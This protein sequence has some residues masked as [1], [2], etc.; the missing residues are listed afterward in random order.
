MRII[1][2]QQVGPFKMTAFFWNGK[3][4]LKFE[5]GANE[6]TYKIKELD[7]TSEG[8]LDVFFK[9]PEIIRKTHEAFSKMDEALDTFY[10]NI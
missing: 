7:V 1:K 3:Y 4:L 10:A 5:N 9:D 2:E 8:D 6:M